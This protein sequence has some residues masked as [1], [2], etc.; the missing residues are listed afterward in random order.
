MTIRLCNATLGYERHPAVHHL[1]GEFPAGSLTAVVGPNGAGKS[2]LLKGIKGMLP[3][4]QGR[5]DVEGTHRSRVAYLPQQADIDRDFPISVLEVV[6]LGHWRRSGAFRRLGKPEQDD[7][8][9]ALAA[10]GLSG[11][12][13]RPVGSLSVGQRQRVLFARVLVEDSPVILLDEPFAA[14]DAKTTGDLLDIVR[15]WHGEQRTVVAV[16]HD[17]E[18]VRRHFPRTLLMAR[19]LVDWGNTDAV[20][21]PANLLTARAMGEAWRDDAAICPGGLAWAR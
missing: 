14:L 1:S 2:T 5:I 8:V 15:H 12:E 9:A 10:V 13:R 7:A 16:M 19:R 18:Q 17:L 4:L 20:L 3:V 21:T 11:F 6:Q